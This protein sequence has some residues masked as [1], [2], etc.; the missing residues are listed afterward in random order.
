MGQRALHFVELAGG[1]RTPSLLH[2]RGVEPLTVREREVALLAAT[3]VSSK[4]IANRL[5]VSKRT[6]DSHLDRAYRKLGVT[7]RD[8]LADA[9]ASAPSAVA[10]DHAR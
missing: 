1:A 5:I 2:G 10:G 9:L 4:E 6:I 7:G 3:G 8:Q